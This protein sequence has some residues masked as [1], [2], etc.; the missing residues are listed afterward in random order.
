MRE[1]KSNAEPA[2]GTAP[3]FLGGGVSTTVIKPAPHRPDGGIAELGSVSGWTLIP[4]EGP[5]GGAP[6]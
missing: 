6:G 4:G 2:G 1:G 5:L 3:I